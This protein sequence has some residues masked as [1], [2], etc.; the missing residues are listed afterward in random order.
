[1]VHGSNIVSTGRSE[2]AEVTK[3]RCQLF[4]SAVLLLTFRNYFAAS[5]SPLRLFF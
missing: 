4:L 1:M 3:N 2:T 5:T